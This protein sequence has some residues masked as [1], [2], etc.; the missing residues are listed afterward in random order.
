MIGWLVA[1]LL[2]LIAVMVLIERSNN[3]EDR[4]IEACVA[5]GGTPVIANRQY[6]YELKACVE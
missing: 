1:L 5:A 3:R 4:K 2:T 6:T